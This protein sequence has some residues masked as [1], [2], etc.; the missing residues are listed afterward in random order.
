MK[1]S[2]FSLIV[3]LMLVSS[4][5]FHPKIERHP[6]PPMPNLDSLNSANNN[7]GKHY[8]LI[9]SFQ[10]ADFNYLNIERLDSFATLDSDKVRQV[11]NPI[12]GKFMVFQFIAEFNGLGYGNIIKTFHDILIIKI[13]QDRKVIDAFQYTL[14]WG[15]MPVSGDLYRLSK[16][17][18]E[19]FDKMKLNKLEMIS[20][21]EHAKDKIEL[22]DEGIVHLNRR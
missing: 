21:T 13:N 19:L 2:I 10:Y 9:D 3:S 14:E 17:S 20:K 6:F 18:V 12:T 5:I 7:I 16:D 4:C 22:I 11:F 15:E 8:Y 1:Q